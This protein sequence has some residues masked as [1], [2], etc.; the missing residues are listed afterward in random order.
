MQKYSTTYSRL[1]GLILD[2]TESEQELLL[3]QALKITDKR[4]MLRIRCLIRSQYNVTAKSYSGYILDI[5]DNGA[6]IETDKEFPKGFILKLK[7]FDPFC[8]KPQETPGEIVWSRPDGIGVKFLKPAINM[9]S[10]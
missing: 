3:K 1:M 9:K 2:M 10:I 7:Y 5:N 8:R 6:F 4:K